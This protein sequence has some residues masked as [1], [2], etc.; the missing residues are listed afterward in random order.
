MEL[1]KRRD[2][3]TNPVTGKRE[4]VSLKTS[5]KDEAR[6]KSPSSPSIR[7]KPLLRCTPARRRCAE[8][9]GPDRAKGTHR[10]RPH[11]GRADR[12]QKHG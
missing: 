12:L 11:P 7:A 3:F 8:L 5:N 2:T 6:S 10:G 1:F 9:R 4:R